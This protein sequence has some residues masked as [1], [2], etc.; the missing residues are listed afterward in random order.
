MA[1]ICGAMAVETALTR[2]YLKWREE[3]SMATEPRRMPSAN[4]G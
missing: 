1:I 4:R 2:V 3:L